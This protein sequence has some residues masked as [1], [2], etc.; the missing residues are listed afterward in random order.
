MAFLPSGR[1]TYLSKSKSA[2]AWITIDWRTDEGAAAAGAEGAG[3]GATGVGAAGVA[4]AGAG[5]GFWSSHS[6]STAPEVTT[7]W[8]EPSR[9]ALPELSCALGVKSAYAAPAASA[10]RA[11]PSDSFEEIV[12][13]ELPRGIGCLFCRFG[14]LV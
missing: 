3:V 6:G 8:P 7:Q 1:T 12:I 14:V 9:M 11:Q 2:S 5:A 10:T 13:F 4:G